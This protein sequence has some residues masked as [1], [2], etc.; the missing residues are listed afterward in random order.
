ML[1]R[2][3]GDARDLRT[4]F[5]R[6]GTGVTIVT[7][8]AADGAWVGLTANSFNTVS[9]EPPIVVWSLSNKSPSLQAFQQ[10][11]A[12]V[13]NVLSQDQ[14]PLSQ[15]FARP[16]PNKFD[17]VAVQPGLRGMPLLMGSAAIFE[18]RTV[19]QQQMGDH[20]LFLGQVDRYAYQESAPLIYLNGQYAQ[21]QA[22]ALTA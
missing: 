10:S 7:T 1:A 12:F 17:S 15:R 3:P 13:V 11:G 21:V 14:L 18:C 6:F 2:E 22:L 8:V 9:L 5:G 4:A 20:V 19:M 16:I